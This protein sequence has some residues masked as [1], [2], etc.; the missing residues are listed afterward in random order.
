MNKFSKN[1][2]SKCLFLLLFL[3]FLATAQPPLGSGKTG[4]IPDITD[5]KP[6][7]PVLNIG[8]DTAVCQ[9]KV[10]VLD[11]TIPE[12]RNC[13]Y[14]WSTGETTAQIIVKASKTSQFSVTVIPSVGC[15]LKD[16]VT[17]SVMPPPETLSLILTP[18]RCTNASDGI[19]GIN[20]IQGGTPPYALVFSGDS[21][22]NQSFMTKLKAGDYP[23][24]VIDKQGCRLDTV[25]KLENPTP[26]NLY[27]AKSQEVALGDSF[28]LWAIGNRALDTFFWS[29]KRIR[30]LDTLIKPFDSQTLSI[31]ATDKFGCQKT[32]VTQIT[33]RRNNLYFAPQVFSPNGDKINDVYQIYGGKTVVSIDNM[34]IVDRWGELVFESPRIFPA[35]EDVGWDGRINGGEALPNVYAFFATITYIDGRK[36]LISGSFT[37][38]R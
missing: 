22:T 25:V 33:V 31:T 9:N 13:V 32:A 36:E 6:N 35:S 8:K 38:V 1:T 11:A 30:V 7:C 16:D 15:E 5:V 14:R 17:I 27:I 21:I 18:P 23:I 34:K 29:D 37:L 28:R 19:I 26:F 12:C 10:V 3:P 2:S 24:G 4:V 20:G